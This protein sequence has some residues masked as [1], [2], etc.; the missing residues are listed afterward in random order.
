MDILW[1]VVLVIAGGVVGVLFTRWADR[2]FNPIEDYELWVDFTAKPLTLRAEV[3]K[4]GIEYVIDGQVMKDPHRVQLYLWR[5]GA[6]DVRLDSFGGEDLILK[7]GVPVSASSLKANESTG[8]AD[9]DFETADEAL[10]RL[11]PSLVRP[12]FAVHYEF[13]TDGVPVIQ[14]F[15]PVADLKMSSFF[16][17]QTNRNIIGKV[18]VTLGVISVI[19]AFVALITFGIM[20]RTDPVGNDWAAR[21]ASL[22]LPM[23]ILGFVSLVLGTIIS[24][25]RARIAVRQLRSRLGKRSLREPQY[26]DVTQHIL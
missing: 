18:L 7:L 13:I 6:K 10:V 21:V 20:Y 12:S 16:L 17:E 15:N 8:G 26:F 5:L 11:R 25:R 4:T 24:P 22:S 3:E 2:W 14:T 9:V 23:M 19:G 1:Q